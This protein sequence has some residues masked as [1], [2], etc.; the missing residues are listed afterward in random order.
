MDERMNRQMDGQTDGQGRN[1][2]AS[3]LLGEGIIILTN[4][5]IEKLSFGTSSVKW[6]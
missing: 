2:Y 4:N 3:S 5:Q 6:D 1:I